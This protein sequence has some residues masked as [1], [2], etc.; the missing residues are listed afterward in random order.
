MLLKMPYTSYV[1]MY[2]NKYTPSVM[3]L[4]VKNKNEWSTKVM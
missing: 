1:S 3:L 4:I 2:T